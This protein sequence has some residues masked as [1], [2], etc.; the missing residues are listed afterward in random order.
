[1]KTVYCE[2]GFA[3]WFCAPSVFALVGNLTRKWSDRM[4]L[5]AATRCP[6][7]VSVKKHSCKRIC[8][9]WELQGLTSGAELMAARE[10]NRIEAAHLSLR[11]QFKHS[12][13]RERWCPYSDDQSCLFA[14]VRCLC[15]R[16][17][18]RDHPKQSLPEEPDTNRQKPVS[19]C[20][21]V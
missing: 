1:M 11:Y 20:C 18:R 7:M 21:V 19:R 9:I 12:A 4:R 5:L 13:I 2:R 16:K 3:P 15:T 6:P 17:H 10:G 8:S 14:G